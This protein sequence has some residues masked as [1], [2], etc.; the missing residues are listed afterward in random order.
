M[1]TIVI[2]GVAKDRDTR[3][4]EVSLF[5]MCS[6]AYHIFEAEKWD[7][8]SKLEKP[9]DF[10]F[11][12]IRYFAKFKLKTKKQQHKIKVFTLVNHKFPFKSCRF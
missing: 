10:Q 9:N 3:N 11:I 12:S 6:Y 7:S 8:L 1:H 4:F 2:S 5:I